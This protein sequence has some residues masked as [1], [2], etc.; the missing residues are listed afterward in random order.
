MDDLFGLIDAGDRL[1]VERFLDRDPSGA[2]ARDRDG[3]SAVMHALYRGQR[4]IAEL[5]AARLEEDG[6]ELNLFEAAS[7]G[8][9]A[10]VERL[11]GGDPAL[12]GSWSSD[13]F[14][15]L[16][17]AAFFGGGDAAAMLLRGGADPDLRSRN[18]FAVMPLHSAVAAGHADVV[19]ALLAAGADPNVRQPHGF[20]ALHGAAQNGDAGIA[21]QL[22]EAGADAAATADD[23]RTA[24]TLAAAGGHEGLAERLSAAMG[25]A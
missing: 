10:T 22:L 7:I 12:A 5:L 16:H 25:E 9:V 2:A 21:E 6:R 11:L 17:Y 3:I 1:A 20:T 14:T 19:A 13:G 4:P 24:V 8:R 23:G 15:A 18:D